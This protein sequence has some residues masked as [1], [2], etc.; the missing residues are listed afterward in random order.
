MLKKNII[1]ASL[2]CANFLNLEKDVRALEKGG[3]DWLHFDIMDG[4]FVPNYTLGPDL[5][6]TLRPVTKLTLDAHLMIEEPIRYVRQ[7]AEAGSDVIV[8]HQEA[9]RHLHRTILAIKEYGKRVGVSINPATNIKVLKDVLGEIDLILIMCVNP[10]FAGQKFIPH[11]V[12]KAKELREMIAKSGLQDR[13][14]L[15]ADGNINFD[16]SASL[17]EAGVTNFVAGTSCIFK[18]GE[19]IFENTVKFRKHIDSFAAKK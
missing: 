8:V 10:G 13:I 12:E 2:M 5:I 4:T 19:D 11:S 1:S 15:Q 7:F 14:E 3:A 9:C 17:N 6:R 18:K 16:T